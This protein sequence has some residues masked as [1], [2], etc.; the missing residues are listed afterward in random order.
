MGDY[1]EDAFEAGILIGVDKSNGKVHMLLNNQMEDD[2]T[3][4]EMRAMY[5]FV[6]DTAFEIAPMVTPNDVS[7]IDYMAGPFGS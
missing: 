2:F 7:S 5:Q 3:Q 4:E 1:N 6:I